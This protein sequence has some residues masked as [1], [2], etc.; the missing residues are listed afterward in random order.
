LYTDVYCVVG[1]DGCDGDVRDGK[2]GECG[3]DGLWR[4]SPIVGFSL[5]LL[6]SALA[7]SP[8]SA[9]AAPRP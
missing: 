4:M 5:S 9:G 1:C 8:R 3:A 7:V 2:G 6:D